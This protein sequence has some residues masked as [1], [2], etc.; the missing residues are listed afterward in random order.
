MMI[1]SE[2]SSKPY[3]RGVHPPKLGGPVL[4]VGLPVEVLDHP[5]LWLRQNVD[6]RVACS[7]SHWMWPAA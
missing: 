3:V 1:G 4:L 6:R 5:L 7:N 2:E